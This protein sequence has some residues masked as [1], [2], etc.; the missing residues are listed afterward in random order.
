LW[1]RLPAAINS[2]KQIPK[3]MDGYPAVKN[4]GMQANHTL[5]QPVALMLTMVYDFMKSNKV[6]AYPPAAEVAG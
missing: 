4:S 5:H 1:E 2:V 6:S 3:I